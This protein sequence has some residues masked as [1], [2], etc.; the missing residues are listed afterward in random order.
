ME[1]GIWEVRWCGTFEPSK[2]TTLPEL[3]VLFWDPSTVQ[4]VYEGLIT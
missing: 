1:G 2:Y 4:G 3:G